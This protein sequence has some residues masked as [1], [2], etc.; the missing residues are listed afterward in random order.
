MEQRIEEELLLS[1]LGRAMDEGMADRLKHLSTSEWE[2]VIRLSA[3]HGVT[4]LLYYRLKAAGLSANLPDAI[5]QRL[6]VIYLQSAA[7]NIRLYHELSKVLTVL[8]DNGIPVIVLKGAY[9]DEVVYGNT[10]LRTMDDVD[11]LFRKEDLGRAQQLLMDAG[12]LSGNSGL[13]LDVH[14]GIDLSIADLD[15]DMER[16]W[17]S[18][19]PAAIAGVEVLALSPED[20]LLHLCLH[21]CFHHLFEFAGLR[22]LCDIRETIMHYHSQ[23]PWEQVRRNAKEWGASN[24]VYLTLLLARDMIC[25]QVPDD[26]LEDLKPE[27]VDLQVKEWAIEQIFRQ[28]S[29]APSLSPYF[30]QLWKPGPFREKAASFRKLLF[31]SPEFV[32]QKYPSPFGSIRTYFYYTV[33]FKDHFVRYARATWRIVI[34]DKKMLLLVKQQNRNIDMREWMSSKK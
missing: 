14:W 11:I 3:R 13:L 7:R 22:A 29:D 24:S 19:R 23:I 31:P 16:L 2:N 28:T 26:V 1:C 4:P 17:K 8:K 25:A 21:L 5:Q 12:Y 33:R 32:S 30:W 10:G 20:F 34:R 15:I 18:S 9:L 6:R 27:K